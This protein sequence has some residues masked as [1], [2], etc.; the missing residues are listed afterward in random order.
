MVGLLLCLLG[1]TAGIA[2]RPHRV[3]LIEV[4]HICRWDRENFTQVI[5]WEWSPC[6]KRY[7]VVAWQNAPPE[8]DITPIKGRYLFRWRDTPHIISATHYR[9]TWTQN[10]PEVDNRKVWP[11]ERMRQ[12]W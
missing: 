7:V 6:L 3:D 10:D 5:L 4:N 9:E 11:V 12:L 2:E 1:S 8:P